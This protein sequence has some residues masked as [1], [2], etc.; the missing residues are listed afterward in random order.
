MTFDEQVAALRGGVVPR[1][2]HKKKADCTPEEW[3]AYLDYSKAM[4]KAW[5][6]DNPEQARASVNKWSKANPDKKRDAE[7]K[8]RASK[9][10]KYRLYCKTYHRKYQKIRRKS[11]TW[12]RIASNLRTR[13]WQFFKGKSRSLSMVKQIGCDREFF[14]R[15]IA[16]RFAVGMTLENYGKVWH[17]DHIYPLSKADMTDRVQFL[18]AANWRNLQPLLGPENEEKSD[19]VTPEAQALFDLLVQEFTRKVVAA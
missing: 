8:C 1:H 6:D 18:A 19:D 15:H 9:P 16:S 14:L 5:R 10:D 3:A 11:D 17:L 7:R 4:S 12:F 13:Q 2:P